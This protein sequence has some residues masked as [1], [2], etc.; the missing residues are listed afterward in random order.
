MAYNQYCPRVVH[1]TFLK[2]LQGFGIE[3][4]SRFVQN[5]HIRSAGK[6]LGEQYS[7]SLTTGKKSHWHPRPLRSKEE[8]LQVTEY[9]L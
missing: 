7:V 4:I 5:D 2:Q 9:M 6:Q 1:E 3:I 8:V